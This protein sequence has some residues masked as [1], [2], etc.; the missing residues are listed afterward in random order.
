LKALILAGGKGTRLRPFSFSRAK[1]LLP[2]ANKPVLFYGLEAVREA[3]I[4]DV[5]IVIGEAG[6]E[7]KEAVGDGSKWGMKVTYIYQE[8][9]LGLA[10]AVWMAREFLE[11][12]PFVLYLGDN[13]L[14]GGIKEFVRL[15]SQKKPDALI[16]LS[17]VARPEQFGVA[18]LNKKGQVIGLVEKPKD[19]PSNLALVGVYIFQPC[20][21][22]AISTLTPSGRGELEITDAIQR[23]VN[24]DKEV[25]P[26]TVSGWWKDTGKKEDLLEANRILLKHLQ[27]VHRGNLKDT[28]IEGRVSTAS[29]SYLENVRITGPV[30]IGEKAI[31][32][33]TIIHP[34]T[35]IGP[36]SCILGCEIGDTIIM[37]GA[38]ILQ[39]ENKIT[40]S[41]IGEKVRVEKQRN[42][43][44]LVM[45]LGDYSS[46]D[47]P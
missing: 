36:E 44:E 20:I 39:V 25:L 3:G 31:I 18:T 4:E 22:D 17:P 9:P 7:I 21:F 6:E 15:F 28:I 2:V 30:I 41:L 42:D 13:L 45:A 10:H 32:K 46:L 8:K 26:F 19:P 24:K 27:P 43:R 34:Y 37:S 14:L 16:L 35:A 40:G 33:N 29:G 23:L 47:L 38:E 5:G 11:N 1:Q 12:S